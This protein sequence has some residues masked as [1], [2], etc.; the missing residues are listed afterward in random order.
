MRGKFV[1]VLVLLAAAAAATNLH[2]DLVLPRTRGLRNFPASVGHWNMVSSTTFSA[3]LLRVLRPSDYTMRSYA[4]AR[5][6]RISMYVGYHDGGKN[7]GPIHSPRNCLPGAGWYALDT[8]EM[9]V[10]TN[11]ESL[12]LVRTVY[13]KDRE[14]V[15]FYYWYQVRG[16]TF[17]SD[18]LMKLAE[19]RN[20]L[21]YRRRD[22]AFIRL[23]MSGIPG[24]KADV[25]A[26]DFIREAYPALKDYLP[27]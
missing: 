16:Q 14:E 23:D 13:A 20:A 8:R 18:W 12:T 22:A 6:N 17:A 10:E 4:D 27:S 24:V 21:L 15:I 26:E 11:G 2:R 9:R 19:L 3:P 1:A 7:A 25:L 5:G